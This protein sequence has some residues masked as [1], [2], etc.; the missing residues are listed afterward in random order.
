MTTLLL[1]STALATTRGEALSSATAF[2]MHQ[3]SMTSRN[4]TADC[5]SDYESDYTAGTYIGLPYDWGGSMP[6]SEFDEGLSDGL[7]AGS[8]SWHGTLSCTVGLDCSG[9]VSQVWQSGRYSTSTFDAVTHDLSRSAL[10]PGD[11]VN[12]AGSH[13]VLFTY[14]DPGNWPMYYEAAGG[15]SKVRMN[16]TGGWSYLDGYQ[17]VRYDDIE[18]GMPEGGDA[19]APFLVDALPFTDIRWSTAAGSDRFDAYNCAPDTDE[20]GPEVIY[21]LRLSAP[22]RLNVAVSDPESVDVD[23]HVL[24]ALN[25]DACIARDDVQLAVDAPAGDVWIVADTYVDGHELPGPYYLAVWSG[26]GPAPERSD[27]SETAT[28]G[29]STPSDDDAWSTVDIGSNRGDDSGAGEAEVVKGSS[30]GCSTLTA[31]DPVAAAILSLAALRAARRRRA[32]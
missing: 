12:D 25:A 22:T 21:H 19:D 20:S 8:H 28:P 4:E 15:P 31:P 6:I 32:R 10:E 3:W 14:L 23:I 27:A 5:S 29:T 16:V 2:A 1:L 9:F 17:P 30:G 7:G 13:I 11:A 26:D 24:T 18:E